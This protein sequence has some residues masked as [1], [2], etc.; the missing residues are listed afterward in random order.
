MRCHA[1][2]LCIEDVLKRC[3]C[4]CNK[5][6]VSIAKSMSSAL[7]PGMRTFAKAP[8]MLM[9]TSGDDG[10]TLPATVP[11]KTPALKQMPSE[12]KPTIDT[13][14]K[15]MSKV[16]EELKKIDEVTAVLVPKGREA[17][18]FIE[19]M[20]EH[21]ATIAQTYESMH[22]ASTSSTPNLDAISSLGATP[23]KFVLDAQHCD[24]AP[25]QSDLCVYVCVRVSLN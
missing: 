12:K 23:L 7:L 6:A 16:I 5:A 14:F 4:E 9:S 8:S 3:L 19:I 13:Y 2:T 22:N 1:A 21:A 10:K 18:P 25:D 15:V 17:V 11:R 24:R 20:K